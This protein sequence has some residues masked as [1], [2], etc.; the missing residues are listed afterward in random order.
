MNKREYI[1]IYVHT[2]ILSISQIYEQDQNKKIENRTPYQWTV[3][4]C[5]VVLLVQRYIRTHVLVKI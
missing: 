3:W 2:I 5:S 1:H 4:L